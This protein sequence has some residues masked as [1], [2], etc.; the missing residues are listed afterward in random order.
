MSEHDGTE[1]AAVR[2]WKD[3]VTPRSTLLCVG[4]F[5]LMLAFALSYVGALHDPKPYHIDLA[6]AAPSQARSQLVGQLNRLPGE[7]V[8]ARTVGSAGTA[9]RQVETRD[10]DG[11]LVV[12][13]GGTARLVVASAG[14]PGV[15]NAL[16]QV[17]SG[18]AARAGLRLTVVDVTPVA[19]AD[20]NELTSFYL[21]VAWSVGG[22]L[23]ASMLGISAGTRPATLRRAA[24]RLL[25]M[26]VYAVV[27]GLGGAVVVGPVLHALP[28]SVGQLWWIG[29]LLVFSTAAFTMALQ[30]LAGVV[31]IGLAIAVFVVLGN[32][33][34]GGVFG[35][36]MLPT[37]WRAIGPWISTGAA[38]QTVRNVAYFGSHNTRTHLLVICAYLVLGV[39]VALLV[40]ALKRHRPR[41]VGSPT[42]HATDTGTQP[43]GR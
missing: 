12:A 3:A 37:F 17:M 4:V 40:P 35:W 10:A 27:A 21:V 8:R 5:A 6:V 23:V 24:I 41:S 2:E 1:R 9:R 11:A 14:G 29:A 38:T 13:P 42:H 30:V 25:A 26:A 7:P 39:L 16:K 20:Y 43:Y 28:A 15:A 31:G 36:P 32:P 22:Y 34:S 18:F 19:H 33:S